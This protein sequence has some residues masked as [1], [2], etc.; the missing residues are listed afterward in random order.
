MKQAVILGF[1]GQTRDRFSHYH[2]DRS[3]EEKLD[4]A[5]RI[6]GV[7]GVEIVSPYD[8]DSCDQLADELR[9]RSLDIAAVNVN[10]KA[11]PEFVA[12]AA[13]RSVPEIRRR[14]IDFIK[15]A[16]DDADRLDA[17][18]VTC[19][20]LSDGFDY[21]F[22]VDYSCAWAN[23][24]DTFAEAAEYRPEIPLLIE[25]KPSETRVQ[26]HVDTMAKTLLLCRE[27]GN[28]ALGVT[29]DVGHAL[30][31]GENP[32]Q[33]LCLAADSGFPYYIHVND[34]NRKFDWD[35][36]GS[37]EHFLHYAEFLFYALEKGYNDFLT[38]DMS[39]RTLD[40]EE[41]FR[42]H[43]EV[44]EGTLRLVRELDRKVFLER[45]AEERT[46]DLLRMVREQILRLP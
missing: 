33:S 9:Q 43:V 4:L 23:L 31:A 41:A 42:R 26:C 18:R 44:T 6:P 34:N 11:E 40:I 27:I 25:Y 46:T 8:I 22:T 39:P 1:L 32:A 20:P 10:I 15:R 24:R 29:L 2:T 12:G 38:S 19:C 35:L 17:P 45:M 5:A 16:K 14:V 3:I 7:S 28:P 21:L 13:S 37:S 36:I 30:Y